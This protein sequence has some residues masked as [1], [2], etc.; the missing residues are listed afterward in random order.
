MKVDEILG[1]FYLTTTPENELLIFISD[2]IPVQ[3]LSS[4]GNLNSDQRKQ[5]IC[6]QHLICSVSEPIAGYTKDTLNCTSSYTLYKVAYLYQKQELGLVM[7]C[8]TFACDEFFYYK[9]TI[10]VPY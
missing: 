8:D 6:H 5:S 9:T 2:C 7:L 4:H 1:T 10:F 3:Q